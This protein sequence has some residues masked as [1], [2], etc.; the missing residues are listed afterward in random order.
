LWE[1]AP[2]T[3][4]CA[5]CHTPHGSSHDKLLV[6]KRP[7]LCQRCHS[8]SR[9]PGTLYSPSTQQV[10]D[11]VTVFQL[12]NRLFDRN[13]QNCHNNMHGSNHPSGKSLG[14]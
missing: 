4:N 8:N 10:E 11:E 12:S 13:C 2:A 7:Y 14:R 9:H 3:E 5:T 6:A 1:H